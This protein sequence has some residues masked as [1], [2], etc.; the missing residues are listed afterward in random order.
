MMVGLGAA[1]GSRRRAC[2]EDAGRCAPPLAAHAAGPRCCALQH[3]SVAAPSPAR[4]GPALTSS[5]LGRMRRTRPG[6]PGTRGS[7]PPQTWTHP[8]WP[9]AVITSINHGYDQSWRCR[10]RRLRAA[11]RQAAAALGCLRCDTRPPTLAAA[12]PPATS[13]DG[14]FGPTRPHPPTCLPS[15]VTRKRPQGVTSMLVTAPLLSRLRATPP[16]RTSH[17]LQSG[18]WAGS[19]RPGQAHAAVG[20]DGASA[21]TCSSPQ[22]ALHPR[23]PRAGCQ[24]SL[25]TPAPPS[26]LHVWLVQV[27]HQQ[28]LVVARPVSGA[29]VVRRR[30]QLCGTAAAAAASTCGADSWRHVA[31]AAERGMMQSAARCSMQQAAR[32][33][34]GGASGRCRSYRRSS[35][36]APPVHKRYEPAPRANDTLRTMCLCCRGEAEGGSR[37]RA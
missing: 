4:T 21:H 3:C 25:P 23:Q 1:G 2:S 22:Q 20:K 7:S 11:G 13:A 12:Q 15:A 31:M 28:Q 33:P 9:P 19:E 30:A 37:V 36:S 34:V 16:V 35:F 26:S 5:C 14:P 32:A 17:T 10:Q 18:G 6:S 24:P 29:D 27:R 8:G